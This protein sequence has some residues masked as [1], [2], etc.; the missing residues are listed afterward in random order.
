MKDA[1]GTDRL[2]EEKRLIVLVGELEIHMRELMNES[3]LYNIV[4]TLHDALHE[5][6][7]SGGAAVGGRLLSGQQDEGL[8]ILLL[9]HCFARCYEIDYSFYERERSHLTRH[10]ITMQ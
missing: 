4:S 1:L 2:V 6:P 7:E 8:V 9:C 10:V 3:T 5:T